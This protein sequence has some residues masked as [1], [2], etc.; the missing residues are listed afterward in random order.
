MVEIAEQ[1][2]AADTIEAT[3]NYLLES[4]ETPYVYTGGPG[5]LDVRTGSTPDPR[6]VAIRNARRHADGF[7]LERE[8][9]RFVRHD[10]GWSIF[11]TRT[12]FAG[13]I[14]RRW[15]RW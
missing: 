9:F 3:V 1:Q 2:A 6:V 14:I 10:T 5:S 12:R 11:S 8:G 7:V 15:K 4:G 13:S